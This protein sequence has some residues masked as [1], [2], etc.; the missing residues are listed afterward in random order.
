MASK[1]GV[2]AAGLSGGGG[3][4]FTIFFRALSDHTPVEVGSLSASRLHP[5]ASARMHPVCTRDPSRLHRLQSAVCSPVLSAACSPRPRVELPPDLS[6]RR[7]PRQRVQSLYPSPPRQ[8]KVVRSALGRAALSPLDA[9]PEEHQAEWDAW[10][11]RYAARLTA[12]GRPARERRDEM[13]LH[14][15]KF[16]LRNWM[17][18]EAYEA[19]ERGDFSLVRAAPRDTP[20]PPPARSHQS[21]PQPE[22]QPEP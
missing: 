3:L 18:V 16:I 11:A 20:P 10:A 21:E 19:A 8:G 6:T 9:W 13:D 22:P 17:A 4:D 5:S 7:G 15:P 14:N 2:G 12:E 1:A